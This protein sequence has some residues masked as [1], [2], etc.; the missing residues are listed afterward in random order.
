M[1]EMY[2]TVTGKCDETFA[3]TLAKISTYV[4]RGNNMRLKKSCSRCDM[5]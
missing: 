5:L 1:I 3:P 2:K 4:T